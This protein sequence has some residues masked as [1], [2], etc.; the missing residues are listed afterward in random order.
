M[1]N[2]PNAPELLL[3]KNLHGPTTQLLRLVTPPPLAVQLQVLLYGSQASS[4]DGLPSTGS[5]TGKFI[6]E[7]KSRE[8]R[9]DRPKPCCGSATPRKQRLLEYLS[10][11]YSITRATH[12]D[13][14][15][16]DSKIARGLMNILHGDFH[17]RVFIEE[18][19]AHQQSRFMTWRQV[20]WMILDETVIVITK[21]RDDEL[22]Q[23]TVQKAAPKKNTKLKRVVALYLDGK[24]REKHVSFRDRLGEKV[25]SAAATTTE[26]KDIYLFEHQRGNVHM[27][28]VAG[29]STTRDK[30]RKERRTRE[31]TPSPHRE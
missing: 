13:F 17:K 6:S 3:P 20:A 7:A 11:S 12:G 16:V 19:R 27:E 26:V 5:G 4:D 29:S 28:K 30:G 25:I 14:E 23:D 1:N 9:A 24:A 10:K 8:D 2:P 22:Q 15:T 18:D 21:K 31:R